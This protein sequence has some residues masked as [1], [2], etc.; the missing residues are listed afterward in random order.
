ME[1][2]LYM[3]YMQNIIISYKRSP[4]GVNI[5]QTLYPRCLEG[6]M[7]SVSFGKFR[8]VHTTLAYICVCA[9]THIFFKLQ[10]LID[11]C[12]G[13]YVNKWGTQPFIFYH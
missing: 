1:F 6:C 3:Y 12:S 2:F 7:Q 9:P 5:V 11:M 10:A 4:I 8:I 13:N